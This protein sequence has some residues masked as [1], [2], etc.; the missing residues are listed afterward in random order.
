MDAFGNVLVVG[1]KVNLWALYY[2]YITYN[3]YASACIKCNLKDESGVTPHP[4]YV[5]H[6]WRQGRKPYLYYTWFP[7]HFY[8]YLSVGLQNN[9]SGYYL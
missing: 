5:L 3:N 2:F 8:T 6:S 7:E 4:N 9:P 1:L